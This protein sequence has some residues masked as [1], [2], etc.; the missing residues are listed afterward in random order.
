MKCHS[1]NQDQRHFPCL[2]WHACILRGGGEKEGSCGWLD[3]TNGDGWTDRQWDSG[4]K[5]V[6]GAVTLQE[7]GRKPL[8]GEEEEGAFDLVS[9]AAQQPPSHILQCLGP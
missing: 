6:F 4:P 1:P 7:R 2:S 9:A 8:A 5:T 3:W